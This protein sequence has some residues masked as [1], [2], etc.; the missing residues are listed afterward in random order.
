M[1]SRVLLAAVRVVAR[2]LVVSAIAIAG[3]ISL[4]TFTYALALWIYG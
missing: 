1:V 3:G 4:L 2:V